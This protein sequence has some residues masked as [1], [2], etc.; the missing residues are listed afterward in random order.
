MQ[1]GITNSNF[2]DD[3]TE[4]LTKV[5]SNHNNII[6]LGDINIHLNE[7]EDIDAEA[8][9][10]IFE[11]FNIMQHINFPTN[12]LSHTLDMIATEIRQNRNVTAI[13]GLYISNHRLI[14]IQLKD[15]KEK[16]PQNRINEIEYRRITDEAIQEFKDKFNTQLI[17]DAKTLEEADY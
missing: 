13:P 2:I 11:A 14:A 12:N 16:K 5:V 17:L 6:I 8:L 3:L 9:C 4:L 15:K 1:Q 10:D 7:P